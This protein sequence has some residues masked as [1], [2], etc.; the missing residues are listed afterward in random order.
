MKG[1]RDIQ[2]IGKFD[3]EINPANLLTA[4][5]FINVMRGRLDCKKNIFTITLPQKVLTEEVIGEMN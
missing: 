4:E 5:K 3:G 2:F 1:V